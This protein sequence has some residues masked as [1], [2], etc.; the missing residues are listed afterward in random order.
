ML[1]IEYQRKLYNEKIK[2]LK[3]KEDQATEVH[4]AQKANREIESS[5]RRTKLEYEF[6]NKE[7]EQRQD[8]IN[9]E[10]AQNQQKI[11]HEISLASSAQRLEAVIRLR[12]EGMSADEID[13]YFR[14]AFNN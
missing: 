9:Q 6:K 5:E 14:V 4:N 2:Y 1:E 8:K 7:L 3:A 11:N 13:A 10:L 12:K